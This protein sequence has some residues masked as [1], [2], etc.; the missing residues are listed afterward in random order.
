MLY[1]NKPYY[2]YHSLIT[3]IL[4]FYVRTSKTRYFKV[5]MTLTCH[6]VRH[7][8]F[9]QNVEKLLQHD[10]LLHKLTEIPNIESV[11]YLKTTMHCHILTI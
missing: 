7:L 10:S 3:I 8:T 5:T 2:M 11:I 9:R 4:Y 6:Y 1:L